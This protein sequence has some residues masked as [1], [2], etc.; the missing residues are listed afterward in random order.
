[1]TNPHV[2]GGE[3]WYSR[4]GDEITWIERD[5]WGMIDPTACWHPCFEVILDMDKPR[6]NKR[7]SSGSATTGSLFIPFDDEMARHFRVSTLRANGSD[8]Q[9]FTCT[10]VG[11]HPEEYN[12]P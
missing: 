5:F 9:N 6:I 7:N 10:Q 1:M 11:I 12:Q 8:N 4:A 2:E 3:Q